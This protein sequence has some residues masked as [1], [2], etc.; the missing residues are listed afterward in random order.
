MY[1]RQ[2]AHWI[3]L[4]HAAGFRLLRML[5]PSPPSDL[6]ADPWATDYDIEVAMKVPQT[7]IFVAENAMSKE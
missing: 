7:I 1:K 3:D 2:T 6:A 5:E 4:L